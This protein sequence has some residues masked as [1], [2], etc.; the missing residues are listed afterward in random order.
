[1][2]TAAATAF[3]GDLSAGAGAAAEAAVALLSLF[4]GST[5]AGQGAKRM[6]T[7][8]STRAAHDGGTCFWGNAAA[9]EEP[10]TPTARA[11]SPAKRRCSWSKPQSRVDMQAAAIKKVCVPPWS[12]E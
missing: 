8:E 1:M 7:D 10:N 12:H 4:Y 6:L 2:L 3:G 9:V 5:G 11:A